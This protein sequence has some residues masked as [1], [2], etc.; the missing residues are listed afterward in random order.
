MAGG[1]LLLLEKIRT[2][3]NEGCGTQ[4]PELKR[5]GLKPRHTNRIEPWLEG[6]IVT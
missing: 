6:F 3:K 4:K 2:L 1:A 5:Q